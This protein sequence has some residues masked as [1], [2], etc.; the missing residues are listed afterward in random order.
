MSTVK[1][2]GL[3]VSMAIIL[4]VLFSAS[5]IYFFTSTQKDKIYPGVRVDELQV[6]GKTRE[7]V[8]NY[9]ERKSLPLKTLN[10]K[11]VFEDKVATISGEELQAGYDAKLAATQAY[12]IGR[13]G[14]VFSDI[15]QIWRARTSGVNLTSIFTTNES[16]I[17]ETVAYLSQNIDIAPQDALFQFEQ[18]K[19]IA[20]APSKDGR[21][22]NSPNTKSLVMQKIAAAARDENLIASP[23]ILDL[24][25]ETV[26]PSFTTENSNTY[27]IAELIG[28]GKS[29]FAGSIENRK[30]NIQR[31]AS[32]ISGRLIP[33][34]EVFSFN[35]TLGD[36]SVATGFLPAYIIQQGR[37][38]LGDGGGVCQVSTTLFR[39]VL[40]AGLPIEERRAHAYRVSYYEQDSGPG[41]D[42]TVFAPS[43]DFKFK[44]DTAHY[45][46]IQAITDISST[47][48][49]FELYGTSDGRRAE[50][51]KPVILSQS[52]PPEDFYQ[53]DPTLEA[54]VVKQV[55]WRA[56]GA[57]VNFN[58]KVMRGEEIIYDKVFF[59]AFQPW[60][61]VFL[62]G[63][64]V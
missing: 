27:G 47:S 35:N 29:K 64:K 15:Y 49:T 3:V 12:T 25:V 56:W 59:S 32:R 53:D 23:M 55:D 46:L 13:S 21:R 34:G 61:A 39:A 50:V 30:K 54:G 37:T 18:G 43:V 14:N 44:N 17:D 33:P 16:V 36:V 48:L 28:V 6:G 62:R 4:F 26:L 20:F 41:L 42:A 9:Y 60:R 24:P 58:Y 19:V 11:L 8:L 52:P 5:T 2:T 45:I 51:T 40:N 57:K 7:E 10:L 22:L 38:V 1:I 63:T 31:A